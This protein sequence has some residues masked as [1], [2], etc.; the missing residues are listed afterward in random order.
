VSHIDPLPFRF[1][2]PG[3]ETLDSTGISSISYRGQGLLH[4]EGGFLAFEWRTARKTQRID[5]SGVATDVEHSPIGTLEVPVDWIVGARLRGGWWWPRLELRAQ[6]LDAFDG[7]PGKH[8][9]VVRLKIRRRDREHARRFVAAIE[10]ER[11][12]DAFPS[13]RGDARLKPPRRGR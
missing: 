4:L 11:D 10:G 5:G 6:K 3:Q 1:R 9:D 8:P 12:V 7:F 13:E 2:V